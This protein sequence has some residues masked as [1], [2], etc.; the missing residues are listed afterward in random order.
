VRKSSANV[1]GCKLRRK[2]DSSSHEFLAASIG[3]VQWLNQT[4]KSIDEQRGK[5]HLVTYDKNV[6][7]LKRFADVG[8]VSVKVGNLALRRRLLLA[9]RGPK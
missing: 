9:V 8:Q 7:F 6:S 3:D 1:V 5:A 4:L 2:P